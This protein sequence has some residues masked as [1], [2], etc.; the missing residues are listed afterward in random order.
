MTAV[1]TRR[2]APRGQSLVEFALVFPVFVLLFAAIVQF[3]MIFWA[4]NTLTQVVRDTGRWAA[5]QQ[6]CSGATILTKANEIAGNS[7]LLGYSNWTAADV[8]V[9]WSGDPCPPT[10][11][12]E[13]SFVE[14]SVAHAI[15][16]FFPWLPVVPDTLH[17]SAEYRLEP[18]PR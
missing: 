16:V 11:N 18:K 10:D 15:P 8:S 4:Q 7:A 2:S 5:T 13:A 14:I 12:T 17:A 1:R 6:D 3:G 9:S